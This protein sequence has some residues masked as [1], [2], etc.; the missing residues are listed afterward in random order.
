VID[1]CPCGGGVYAECCGRYLE[2]DARAPTAGALM[3]SRYTAYALGK[4]A[5]LYAT[6]P[7]H[8]PAPGPQPRWLGLEVRGVRRGGVLD[9]EGTV[10]F[11]AT[12]ELG[13]HGERMHEVSRF[14]RDADGRWIYV[15][16]EARPAKPVGRN[17]V[18]PCGSR[19]KFKRCC[20]R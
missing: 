2:S 1:V 9:R 19:R 6:G 8:T 12:Y 15:G 13:G 3:R 17:E 10:E 20:G 11:V 16:G 7:E 4:F 14:E 18:C 5:Y